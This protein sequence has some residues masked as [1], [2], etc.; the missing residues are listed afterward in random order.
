V[1]YSRLLAFILFASFYA[2]GNIGGNYYGWDVVF[3]WF[4][5][6]NGAKAID[7]TF[8]S[9]LVLLCLAI[10]PSVGQWW[11]EWLGAEGKE[12]WVIYAIMAADLG[13]NTIGFYYLVM[14]EFT[15]PPVMSV[16]VFL[17]VLAFIPNVF[18]QSL[19]TLNLKKLLAELEQQRARGGKKPA[20]PPANVRPAMLQSKRGEQALARRTNGSIPLD[21]EELQL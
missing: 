3:Q 21:I 2:L 20:M 17:S 4:E 10:L 7:P 6:A 9:P 1:R 19:A 8:T 16:F 18:C 12:K 5:V 15:F 11:R 14:G 13:I